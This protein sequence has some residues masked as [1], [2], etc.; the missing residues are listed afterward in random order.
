MRLIKRS[1]HLTQEQVERLETISQARKCNL[2]EALRIQLESA[3]LEPRM[4]EIEDRMARLERSNCVLFD[5][6]SHL[7]EH[8]GY[9]FGVIKSST[10]DGSDADVSG[11]EVRSNVRGYVH[12]MLRNFPALSLEGEDI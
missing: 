11:L 7:S 1:F 10:A 3:Q 2:N 8:V 12:H 5:T 9:I 4:E 6:L